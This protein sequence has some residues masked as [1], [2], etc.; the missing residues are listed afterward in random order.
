[1]NLPNL[2]RTVP[3]QMAIVC[4]NFIHPPWR[5]QQRVFSTLL[6]KQKQKTTTKQQQQ[7]MHH[8]L[9]F[10]FS[11]LSMFEIS[12]L[13]KKKKK[14]KKHTIWIW[15]VFIW[16]KSKPQIIQEILPVKQEA[17]PTHMFSFLSCLKA[18][19]VFHNTFCHSY[20]TKNTSNKP[21]EGN[22]HQ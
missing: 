21:K 18:S 9:H 1:M 4:F 20:H 15:H 19:F 16:L 13:P 22:K 3:V 14:K 10:T 7:Q 8:W 12:L 11:L 17:N 5:Q 2:E 6:P